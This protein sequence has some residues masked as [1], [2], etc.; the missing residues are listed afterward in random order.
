[1][2]THFGG[3][4]EHRRTRMWAWFPSGL[5]AFLLAAGG[6]FAGGPP[7]SVLDKQHAKVKQVMEVQEGVTPFL[8]AAEDVLGTATGVDEQGEVSLVVYVNPHGKATAEVL[9]ALPKAIRGAPVIVEITEP[10]RALR[11]VKPPPVEVDHTASQQAPI[12]LGTSG[13]WGYDLANG[14]CCGGTLGALVEINGSPHILSNYHVFE[15]D[16]VPGGNNDTAAD[17]DPVL[18]PGLMDVGC[19]AGGALAVATLVRSASL[20]GSNVDAAVA[21]VVPGMVSPDGAILEIGALSAQAAGASLRQRVKKSGR[22]SGLTR[23]TV[24]GLNATVSVAYD[25]EC[26]GGTAFTKVFT[27]QIVVKNRDSSFL[28]S[29]DS[30]AVLV[31]DVATSPGAV[32]LLY[33]GSSTLAV[34]NPIDDVLKFFGATMVGR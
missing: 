29:G 17:G 32:G 10:F 5:A 23:S 16:I 31:E 19:G 33:A 20:P 14:Y 1:M 8:M 6:V 27:G 22:T 21:R 4:P 11:R 28:A 24:T 30:G 34:A 18:H 15:G 9:R 12:Q 13:G 25:D 7:P 3:S 2:R 26:A